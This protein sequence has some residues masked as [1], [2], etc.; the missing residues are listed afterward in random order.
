MSE[1]FYFNFR[2]LYRFWKMAANYTFGGLRSAAPEP[3]NLHP[4][5]R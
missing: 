2:F 5:R 3:Q 4:Q 1:L